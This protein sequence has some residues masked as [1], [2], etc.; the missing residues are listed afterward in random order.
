MNAS[1]SRRRI[2]QATGAALATAA[3]PAL[4][5]SGWPSRPPLR[6][7]QARCKPGTTWRA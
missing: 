3:L 7:P 2:V 1:L 5:Q 4:A 6:C